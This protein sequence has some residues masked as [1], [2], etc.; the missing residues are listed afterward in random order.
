ML[1]IM[2]GTEG[3]LSVIDEIAAVE[4]NLPNINFQTTT[5]HFCT[6]I[7]S[8][9]PNRR[10]MLKLRPEALYAFLYP[11]RTRQGPNRL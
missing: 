6:V 1:S 11:V 7:Y 2:M 10:I 3:A 4:K 5:A 9:L 8:K